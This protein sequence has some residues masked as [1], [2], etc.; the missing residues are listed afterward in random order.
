M[1]GR[2]RKRKVV[3][4]F[5]LITILLPFISPLILAND[6]VIISF[7]PRQNEPPYAPINPDPSNGSVD[8]PVPVILTV[9]V[10]DETGY[11]VDVYFYN[12]SN[13]A[14]IG[15]DYAVPCD[16]STAS[17]VWNEPIKGR[18]CYWYTV[19]RDLQFENRSDTWI[20]ATRPN[21]PSI[22]QNNEYPANNSINTG[23]NVTCHIGINDEDADLMT[24]Y[25][26]ENSTGP[27][28]L[29][30]TNSSV[31]N[32]TYYWNYQ[33]ATDY[34]TT[35]YWMVIV[36]D[37]MHNTTAIFDFITIPNQPLV[38]SNPNPSNQSINV[39][40]ATPYWY[41]TLNDPEDDTI[42]WTIETSPNIGNALGTNDI[43]GQK[44][45]PISGL[46]YIT[47]YTVYV[48]ASD[49]KSSI[50][51]NETFWF[52]TA[53]QGAP[54]ISNE[55]P[56]H[57]NT[58]TELQPI[59]HVDVQDIEGD[60]LTIYWYENST[61]SWVLRKT[62][63]NITANS[64]VYWSFS[65]ADQYS[66]LYYWK[67]VVYDGTVNTTATYFFTTKPQPTSPPSPPS[68]GGYIPLP[69]QHPIA[70]ITAP[71]SGYVDET[72]IFYAYYSEDR[73]GY[74]VGYRWDFDNDG[75][76][77]T[78]WI[79]DILIN[80][81]YSKPGN[82]TV[83]LQVIDDDGAI[84]TTAHNIT[85]I[86]LEPPLQI[87]VP[88]IN[89][90]YIAYINENINF[91]S[92]E[93]YDPDGTIINYTWYFGDGNISF[94]QNPVHAYSEP[95]NYTVIL[96]VTDNDN[97][98]NTTV[99]KAIILDRKKEQIEK[100]GEKEQPLS[101]IIILFMAIIVTIIAFIVRTKKIRFTILIEK[102]DNSKNN[103]NKN[104]DIDKKID[105]L[106]SKLK[107]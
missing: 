19:A 88:I 39:S 31:P 60:N 33:Q 77:D 13:D 70:I 106:L 76:Y 80:Y 94:L 34:S 38:I 99:S 49:A 5:I 22:I 84:T 73:D 57:R 36:N 53:E 102:L 6:Q 68:G 66:T 3:Q 1:E 29:R 47:N 21:Q 93:S 16:W 4:L 69:N 72:I 35:Y 15:V 63:E 46:Q 95:G 50:S 59:C 52:I 105:E 12:A 86:K 55:Y 54:T 44:S 24:I 89:G 62:D 40:I 45:C 82:Y 97:L 48:N 101:F 107:K 96:R 10:Y 25:W 67:V 20:F 100:P 85:I 18:I 30:Q 9:D 56:P 64:T 104:T 17:V 27:W 90:P 32:G 83:R 11:T 23:L 26:F 14:L 103:K 87:P 8:V 74:I 65:Q 98:S 75:V 58:Q 41:V 71:N 79:E 2:N 78:D 42:N 92:N 81:S 51:V 7:D 91:N 43:S 28:I 37:S 61:G